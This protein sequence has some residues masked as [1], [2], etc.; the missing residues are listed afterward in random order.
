MKIE[1]GCKAVIVNSQAGNNGIVVTVIKK[2]GQVEDFDLAVG[3]RWEVDA[4][5]KSVN[6]N[7]I[8]INHIGECQLK[9]IDDDSRQVVSW[10][11]LADIWTPERETVEDRL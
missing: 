5:L 9:R 1:A 3:D 8:E 7:G 11:E 10:S 4:Y 2:I 6:H